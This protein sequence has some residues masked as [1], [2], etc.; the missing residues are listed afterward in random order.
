MRTRPVDSEST[1]GKRQLKP[2]LSLAQGEGEA[3]G[4]LGTKTQT[5]ATVEE[6]PRTTW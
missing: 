4:R 2:Q 5:N 6:R 3:A 1:V